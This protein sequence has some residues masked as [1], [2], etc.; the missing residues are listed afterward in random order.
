MGLSRAELFAAVR[1]DKRLDPGLSQ[2][3][4]SEKYSVH[5]RTVRQALESAVPPR[6]EQQPR[7]SVLDPAKGWIDAMLWDDLTAP[8]KQKHT[9]RRVYRRLAQEHGFDQV[10]YSTVSDYVAVGS[11]RATVELESGVAPDDRRD[12]V[13]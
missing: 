4:L 9:A 3:A 13:G 1:R 11:V 2:R 6:K 5:R 10:S 7:R 8:R 12:R